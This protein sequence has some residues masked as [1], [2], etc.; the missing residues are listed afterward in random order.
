MRAISRPRAR[1]DG[2]DVEALSS[3]GAG[4]R[5]TA[6]ARRRATRRARLQLGPEMRREPPLADA[7]SAD[8]AGSYCSW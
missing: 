3:T 4:M 2:H 6:S 7:A 5:W 8:G 1:R